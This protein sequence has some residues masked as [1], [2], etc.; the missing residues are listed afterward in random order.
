VPHGDHAGGHSTDW[1]GDRLVA[2]LEVGGGGR[3]ARD[4]SAVPVVFEVDSGPE[5][6]G[7]CREGCV[8]PP[9]RNSD[10]LAVADG[11][12]GGATEEDEAVGGLKAGALLSCAIGADPPRAVEEEEVE[13]LLRGYV[14]PECDAKEGTCK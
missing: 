7:G 8:A 4:L 11:A 3:E 12:G 1:G 13:V 5:L 9:H 6:H 14:L 2:Q 10:G